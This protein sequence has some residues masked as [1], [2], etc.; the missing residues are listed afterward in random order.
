MEAKVRASRP[1]SL[2]GDG[3]VQRF[4]KESIIEK[5][6]FCEN[7][8]Q[9]LFAK[10]GEFLPFV[11]GGKEG[12]SHQC[13]YNYGLISKGHQTQFFSYGTGVFTLTVE[14]R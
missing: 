2:F 1:V 12:F 11:K 5:I 6:Y 8:P 10:E 14:P 9:P 7:L 13:P 3:Y 4:N